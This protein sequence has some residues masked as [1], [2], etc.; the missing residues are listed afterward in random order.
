MAWCLTS[1]PAATTRLPKSLVPRKRVVA[2]ATD[3]INPVAVVTQARAPR[4]KRA[5]RTLERDTLERDTLERDT[6]KRD[7]LKR[8][9]LK[10]DMLKRD[11]LK[12]DT[13]KRDTLK[14]VSHKRATAAVL[15]RSRKKVVTPRKRVARA[16]VAVSRCSED[17]VATNRAAAAKLALPR[18]IA[19]LIRVARVI[20][21]C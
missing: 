10:R 13:L 3:A 14:R 1:R 18:K 8:D 6:L 12:R 2:P 7:M 11:M 5:N 21:V 20:L 17:V 15:V 19:A 4:R 16:T 9:M